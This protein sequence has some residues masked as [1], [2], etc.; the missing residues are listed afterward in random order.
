MIKKIVCFDFDGT[1]ID[2]PGPEIGRDEWEKK[3]GLSWAGRGW[4]GN[5]ESLNLDVF[6][7]PYNQWVYN[8]YLKYVNDPECHVFLATG[9]LK[10]LE[11]LVVDILNFHNIKFPGGVYCNTGGETFNFKTKLFESK[12]KEF[13]TAEE[14]IM[15]D[16]R[17]EHLK[18]FVEWSKDQPI[19]VT[20]VDVINKKELK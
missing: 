19:D 13:K 3:T 20:I 15:F 8:H 2:T 10:K 14:F 1:L 4:W 6:Y 9:R 17:W 7:I 12:I 11:N 16:D 18:K 5:A